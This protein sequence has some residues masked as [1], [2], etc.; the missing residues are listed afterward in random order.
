MHDFEALC[1]RAD[2]ALYAAKR[3]GRNR[4][5]QADDGEAARQPRGGSNGSH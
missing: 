5:R 2:Q 1:H 3:A 4:V